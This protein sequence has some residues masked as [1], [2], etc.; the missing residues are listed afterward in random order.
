MGT[1]GTG[2]LGY[3]H[4]V[5]VLDGSRWS[6]LIATFRLPTEMSDPKLDPHYDD[7]AKTVGVT[8]TRRDESR[9]GTSTKIVP[10]IR[11]GY[12]DAE[13]S[14]VSRTASQL[15]PGV[16]FPYPLTRPARALRQFVSPAT[17]NPYVPN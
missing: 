4:E 10:R 13:Q 12:L 7:L 2:S 15:T 14:E 3:L 17:N 8:I 16:F 11:D 9:T 1:V 6:T 5:V